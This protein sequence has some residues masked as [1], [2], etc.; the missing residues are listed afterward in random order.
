[1]HPQLWL[2][3]QYSMNLLHRT[4]GC[5]HGAGDAYDGVLGPPLNSV[6]PVAVPVPF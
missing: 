1:M 6:T 5:W 2:Y 3:S 4:T